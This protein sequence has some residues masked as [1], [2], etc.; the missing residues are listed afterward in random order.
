M[1]INIIKADKNLFAIYQTM[2]SNVDMEMWYDWDRRLKDTTWTE[3]CY[4]LILDGKKIG[5]AVITDD[6]ILYPFLISPFCDRVQFWNYL[7]K[8]SSRKKITGVL[9]ADSSILPMFAYKAIYTYRLM[10]RPSEIIDISLPNG[11]I[12]RPL[13]MDSDAAGFSNVYVESHTGGL[14]FEIF[15]EET[16]EE[17]VAEANRV[18][19]IY[20]AKDMSIVIVEQATG[21]IVAACTAGI[22]K[23]HALGFAEIADI[24]VLPKY[25][26]RGIGK[27]MISHIITQ[28][29]GIAPFVKLGAHM[30]NPSEYLYYQM[31]FVAGPRFTNM[32]QRKQ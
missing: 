5:G 7:L 14:C 12:C 3:Q 15:G 6:A 10:C 31:G 26:G 11:F 25:S 28:A 19:A 2:Y 30:G 24:V 1:D 20:S 18:L 17:A 23:D 9:D 13:N 21:Q 22:A 32:E 16:H 27:Y 8:L 4:F 29:Y